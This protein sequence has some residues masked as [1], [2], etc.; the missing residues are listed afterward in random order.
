ML[1]LLNNKYSFFKLRQ[2]ESQKTMIDIE[3]NYLLNSNMNS[4]KFLSSDT[5][6]LI[7]INPRYEGSQL[8]LTLRSRFLKGNF[9]IVQI[10]PLSNITCT[11][12]NLSNNTQ[13]LRSLVEGND[14]FCQEIV[15]A[16]NPIL[17]SNSEIFKRKDSFNLVIL[18]KELI[19]YINKYSYSKADNELN[20]L[21]S[22]LNENGINNLNSFKTI[23]SLDFRKSQGIYFLNN[24]YNIKKL[25]NLKL[26]NFFQNSENRNRL[27]ITQSNTLG[28]K[29]L[30][31]LKNNF[32]LN[33]QVHLPNNVFFETSGSYINTNGKINKMTKI[34]T[35]LNQTKSD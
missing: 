20:I 8:S 18:L 12:R 23:Q 15:N 19:K 26:L 3:Q 27:L 4:S 30:A 2:S 7:G 16:S 24:S 17:I 1:Y 25:L 34:I 5:C 33:T 22:T 6:L 32:H 11:N 31:V 35:S 21:S 10:S 29:R 13:T 28:T 14:L 9:N